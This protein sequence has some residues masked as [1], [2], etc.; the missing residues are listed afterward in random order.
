MSTRRNHPRGKCIHFCVALFLLTLV[1]QPVAASEYLFRDV[2]EQSFA[3]DVSSFFSKVPFFGSSHAESHTAPK[4]ASTSAHQDGNSSDEESEVAKQEPGAA[5][6]TTVSNSSSSSASQ[7]ASNNRNGTNTS[8]SY[9]SFNATALSAEL[10][11]A[12]N[13]TETDGDEELKSA[14][15]AVESE[16]TEESAVHKALAELPQ[17]TATAAADEAEEEPTAG[18]D[19]KG[20][21]E[22]ERTQ[23]ESEKES[24]ASEKTAVEH[25]SSADATPETN[26][27]QAGPVLQTTNVLAHAAPAPAP[28]SSNITAEKGSAPGNSSAQPPVGATQSLE[29]ASSVSKKEA[30]PIAVSNVSAPADA[31]TIASKGGGFTIAT[32]ISAVNS[33]LT[34]LEHQL[35]TSGEKFCYVQGV[36]RLGDG[37]YLLPSWMEKLSHK[38]RQCGMR[39]V[40]Y[41]FHH[42]PSPT[43]GNATRVFE[44]LPRA[45]INISDEYKD[46]DV[47]G[48]RKPR[49]EFHLLISDLTPLILLSDIFKR[50]E[51]YKNLTKTECFAESGDCAASKVYPAALNPA[52]LVDSAVSE[53]KDYLWPK[54]IV[55]LLRN[56]FEGN[57]QLTDLQDIYGWKFRSHASCFRSLLVTNANTSDFKP[58]TI[59]EDNFMF[60]ANSL[61]RTPV[62]KLEQPDQRRRCDMKVLIMNQFQ[63]GH[64]TGSGVLER[65]LQVLNQAVA[66]KFPHMSLQAETVYFQNSSFHEQISVVQEADLVVASHSASNANLAFLRPGTFFLELLPFGVRP[67]VFQSIARAY[68]V[69]YHYL[70]AEPD[71]DLFSKCIAHYNTEAKEQC[72]YLMR[73]WNASSAVFVNATKGKKVNGQADYFLPEENADDDNYSELSNVRECASLQRLSVDVKHLARRVM[74]QAF[75]QCGIRTAELQNVVFSQVIPS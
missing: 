19:A 57:L 48:G 59:L 75:E 25:P 41:S 30:P 73:K 36:C 65:A 17:T 42:V 60:K 34:V 23:T 1:S 62:P 15:A 61:R 69:D 39:K 53:V 66:R 6:L 68:D 14:E 45:K 13:Q 24:P 9:A 58:K 67:D 18:K 64:I 43:A 28:A 74:T 10:S 31:A 38:V 70:H 7:N 11:S 37:T 29:S 71:G 16:E 72:D 44:G 46:M 54:G 35:F 51:A 63:K 8:D 27:T 22:E 49:A 32:N 12:S 52:I 5:N 4:I 47:V 33:S 50:P 3:S 21:K 56:G 40:I 26:A 2:D 55:R 20:A